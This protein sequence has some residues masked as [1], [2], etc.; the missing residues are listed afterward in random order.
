MY[1]GY[2]RPDS[3]FSTTGNNFIIILLFATETKNGKVADL[4]YD[5]KR[6]RA[7]TLRVIIQR[8]ALRSLTSITTTQPCNDQLRTCENTT[9]G[10]K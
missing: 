10:I 1:L 4:I 2:V 6:R 5:N 7:R 3:D 8:N 9:A